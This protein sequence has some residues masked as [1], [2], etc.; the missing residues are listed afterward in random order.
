MEHM[1]EGAHSLWMTMVPVAIVLVLISLLVMFFARRSP[2]QQ[3]LPV[4][5]L[6]RTGVG[7]R[8]HRRA[9]AMVHGTNN[10]AGAARDMVFVLPDISHYTRFM[11]VNR[12]AFGH[13]QHIVF[14]LINAMFYADPAVVGR[15]AIGAAVMDIFAA[16]FQAQ[17]KLLASNICPCT[18]CQHILDLDLKVLVHRGE[19]SPFE[20]RGAVDFFGMDMIVLHRLLKNTVRSHRYIMIT[21]AAAELCRLP[22]DLPSRTISETFEHIGP[23]PAVVFELDDAEVERM[24]K[25][26]PAERGS[27]LRETWR[28]I[29]QNVATLVHAPFGRGAGS[30][31]E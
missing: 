12:F 30:A 26:G 27:Q 1:S 19:A 11:T 31:P 5:S 18:A 16:F 20:F 25:D 24:R 17:Q 7:R 21:E 2:Q 10:V 14:E 15:D 9:A 13:A 6:T 23:V 3:H 4:T 29:A 22:L 8:L 28:K